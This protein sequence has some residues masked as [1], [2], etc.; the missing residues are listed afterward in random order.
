MNLFCDI[1]QF[2][3]LYIDDFAKIIV[4]RQ[5]NIYTNCFYFGLCKEVSGNLGIVY[6]SVKK[7]N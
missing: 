7:I 3:T 6:K 4:Y 2:L 1:F 5:N